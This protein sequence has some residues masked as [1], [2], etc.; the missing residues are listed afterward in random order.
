M[1]EFDPN[2]NRFVYIRWDNTYIDRMGYGSMKSGFYSVHAAREEME[3]FY[4]DANNTRQVW[5][6]EVSKDRLVLTS[7]SSTPEIIP[8]FNRTDQFLK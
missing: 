3:I 4:N 1:N 5:R 6:F 7:R 2:G 8:E